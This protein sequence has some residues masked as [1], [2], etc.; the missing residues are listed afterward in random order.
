[1]WHVWQR[2]VT[3]RPRWEKRGRKWLSN[4]TKSHSSQIWTG[5]CRFQ[6][7]CSFHYASPCTV[8]V[9]LKVSRSKTVENHRSGEKEQTWQGQDGE[10]ACR[11]CAQRGESTHFTLACS[12]QKFPQCLPLR[13]NITRFENECSMSVVTNR[14]MMQATY[15]ISNFPVATLKK[16]RDRQN[17][18]F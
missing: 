6:T 5:S 14:N 16:S 3:P 8:P 13:H 9:P 7:T 17:W 11:V 4:L 1:M 2:G 18:F 15:I 12:L 10:Q